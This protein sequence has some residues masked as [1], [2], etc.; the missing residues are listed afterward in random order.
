MIITLFASHFHHILDE[1][2][3]EGALDEHG[4]VLDNDISKGEL[5]GD[6]ALLKAALHNTAAVL[7][8]ANLPTVIHTGLINELSVLS[9]DL[10]A[11]FVLLIGCV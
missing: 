8:S 2:V 1:I 11:R 9:T 5:L 3:A 7:V 4:S 10:R 6:Q